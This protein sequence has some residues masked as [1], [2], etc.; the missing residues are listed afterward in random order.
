MH[1]IKYVGTSEYFLLNRVQMSAETIHGFY[2][3][4]VYTVT[5]TQRSCWKYHLSTLVTCFTPAQHTIN[6]SNFSS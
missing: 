5:A 2:V 1:K 6:C 3:Y 4:Y